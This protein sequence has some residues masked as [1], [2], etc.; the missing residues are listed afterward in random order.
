MTAEKREEYLPPSS[1][2]SL[3]PDLIRRIASQPVVFGQSLNVALPGYLIAT[4]AARKSCDPQWGMAAFLADRF[5][6]IFTPLLLMPAIQRHHLSVCKRLQ[7]LVDRL[8]ALAVAPAVR[9]RP[10]GTP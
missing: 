4:R 6:C 7:P 5:A 2:R 10:E 8:A 3:Y 1:G 9:L